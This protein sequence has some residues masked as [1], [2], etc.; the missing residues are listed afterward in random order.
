MSRLRSGE[1]GSATVWVLGC[2]A[3]LLLIGYASVLRSAAVLARH[4]VEAAADL[5]AL[6]AAGRIG[7]G[8]D[9]CAAARRLAARNGAQLAGCTPALGADGRSGT[10]TVQVQLPVRLA[11]LG[12]REVRASARAGR[13]AVP[14]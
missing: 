1:L 2:C 9:I 13:A 4:R 7:I 6:A 10:V 3:L 11:G 12:A 8:D 14:P 5:A